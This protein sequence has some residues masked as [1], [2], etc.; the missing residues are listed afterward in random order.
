MREGLAV[1]PRGI[2]VRR[3]ERLFYVGMAVVFLVTV[4]AGFSRSYFLKAHFGTPELSLML[5][6]HGVV[7]T[8][9]ILLFL[10]QTT[11]AMRSPST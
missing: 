1:P 4:F 8:S 11:L 6:V 3:H 10:A 5:H 7:F 2:T 9:W